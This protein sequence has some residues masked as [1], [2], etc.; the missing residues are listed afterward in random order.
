M[1]RQFGIRPSKRWGQHFLV[2]ARALD[3][4]VGAA[5]LTRDD[6]VLEVGP[7]L[8]TLTEELAARA[9]A[10]TAI[11]VDGRLA[12]V[13]RIRLGGLPNVRI[14]QGDALHADLAALFARSGLR[15]AVANLPYNV[16]APLLLRLLDPPLAVLRLVVTV[17]REVAERVVARAGTP[18]YGR[19]SVAVQYRAAAR[20]VSRIPPGAFLPAPDVESAVLVLVP[21]PQPPV[22]TGDEVF[23]FRVVAA[24]FGHRRKTLAN[25]IAQGLGLTPSAVDAACRS[26]GVDPRVRAETLDLKAF[27]A[28]ARALTETA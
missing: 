1:L 27:A 25:A 19:L 3:A 16:A 14:V 13:V 11:E 5:E 4:I 21:H 10:V 23:L 18:A 2:S 24:G 20:I 9:G 26:A 22:A 28:L 8:G 15:K 12:E 17:Q 7:G 6:A